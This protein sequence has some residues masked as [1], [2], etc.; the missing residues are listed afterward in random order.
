MSAPTTTMSQSTPADDFLKEVQTLLKVVEATKKEFFEKRKND[1]QPTKQ[2]KWFGAKKTTG[3]S[4]NDAKT[5]DDE[6]QTA[7]KGVLDKLI[8]LLKNLNKLIDFLKKETLL[9][10]MLL[11][12]LGDYPTWILISFQAVTE[13]WNERN[14]QN[15]LSRA[16]YSEYHK[17]KILQLHN[18]IEEF[19][20]QAA[21]DVDI[22]ASLIHF[23]IKYQDLGEIRKSLDYFEKSLTMRQQLHGDTPHPD[24]AKSLTNVGIAYEDLGQIRTGLDYL[25]KSL[26]MF[27]QLYGDTPHCDIAGALDN[28]GSAYEDLGKNREGL[29]YYQKALTMRQQLYGGTP[30]PDIARSLNN[31]GISYEALGELCKG[32]EYKKKSLTMY[33]QLHGD[34]PHPD[35]AMSLNN[36]GVAYQAH[37]MIRK[38]LHYQEQSLMM[39]QQLHGDKPHPNIAQSL[40][41]VGM[42][43]ATL[44]EYPLARRYFTKGLKLSR[45]MDPKLAGAH[46]AQFKQRLSELEQRKKWRTTF[47]S[48]SLAVVVALVQY[49][50]FMCFSYD[51]EIPEY[52]HLSADHLMGNP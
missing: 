50:I 42:A 13:L 26:T 6:V 8:Q 47:W 23:G 20:K 16:R 19:Q 11:K 43:H 49:L 25:E 39:D 48:L 12:E 4:R 32:L 18:D 38:G 14:G 34:T 27:Q 52:N 31:V 35:I 24:I 45:Q 15:L 46:I 44:G 10:A 21:L 37:G 41:N 3:D 28:I 36:V 29:D 1:E 33:Q 5:A 22:D 7:I 51:N 30:H 40:N 2:R 17:S 9:D